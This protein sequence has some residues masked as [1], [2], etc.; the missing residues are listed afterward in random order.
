MEFI[1]LTPETISQ[2]LYISLWSEKHLA[3]ILVLKKK[4]KKK[5]KFMAR[6]L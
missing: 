4:K 5:Y 2:N 6:F 3:K 1:E